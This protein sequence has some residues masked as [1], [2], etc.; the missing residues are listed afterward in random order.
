MI[1]GTGI[2]ARITTTVTRVAGGSAMMSFSGPVRGSSFAV[3]GARGLFGGTA[4]PG[5]SSPLRVER[6]RSTLLVPVVYDLITGTLTTAATMID[7]AP[8]AR[9]PVLELG[10]S[11]ALSPASSLRL[12]AAPA[13]DAGHVAGASDTAEFA[14]LV[15]R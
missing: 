3:E 7:L 13:F 2:S 9:E 5:V 10:W 4:M 14:T 1:A 15:L 12:G 8:D 11:A 6:A